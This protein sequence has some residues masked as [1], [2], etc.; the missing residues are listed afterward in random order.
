LPRDLQ[1]AVQGLVADQAL[2]SAV[3][4][5]FCAEFI[6]LKQREWDD[7]HQTI[8]AWEMQRYADAF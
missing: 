3:G 2:V 1:A 6:R 7:Y 5:T 8:T 4:E